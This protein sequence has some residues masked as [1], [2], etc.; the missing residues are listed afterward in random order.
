MVSSRFSFGF[1]F[2]FFQKTLSK[3]RVILPR[4]KILK[5]RL[6]SNHFGNEILRRSYSRK[7]I[8]LGSFFWTKHTHYTSQLSLLPNALSVNGL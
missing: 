7:N 4:L 3:L 5:L 6:I 8:G 2:F 1:F